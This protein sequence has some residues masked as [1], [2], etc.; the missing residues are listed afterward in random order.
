[1]K[2]PVPGEGPSLHDCGYL[3]DGSFEALTFRGDYCNSE[4]ELEWAPRATST[5]LM[6]ALLK[7]FDSSFASFPFV[8][9]WVLNICFIYSSQQ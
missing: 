4:M 2:V 7:A 8:L 3:R 6:S 1:M 5:G 9:V